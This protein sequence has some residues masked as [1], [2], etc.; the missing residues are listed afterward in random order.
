MEYIDFNFVALEFLRR[1][2]DLNKIGI[3]VCL[4]ENNN[5]LKETLT[6]TRN[7]SFKTYHFVI[8]RFNWD[9]FREFSLNCNNYERYNYRISPVN[10]EIIKS[11]NSVSHELELYGQE[12]IEFLNQ[13]DV[14]YR[15]SKNDYYL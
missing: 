5:I 6:I 7:N 1:E 9:T 14:L 11:N 3:Q 12:I 4:S 8:E 10:G 15:T 13:L 2:M